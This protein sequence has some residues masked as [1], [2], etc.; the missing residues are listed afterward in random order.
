[1]TADS[2]AARRPDG[3]VERTQAFYSRWARLYDAIAR[4]TP[5]VDSLR[6]RAA[7]RLSPPAGGVVG[8]MG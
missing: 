6:S 4:W 2:D 1:M 5:G 3:G 8:E 7:A